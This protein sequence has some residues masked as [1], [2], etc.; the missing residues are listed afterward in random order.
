MDCT[1]PV[2]VA[3]AAPVII[4]AI[5]FALFAVV[6][7]FVMTYGGLWL[8]AYMSNANVGL[9]EMVGMCFRRVSARVI[10]Q[11]KIMAVQS[12]IG[13]EQET[14]VTTQRLEYHYLAG[15]NVLNVIRAVIAAHRAD[16]DLDFDR[17]AEID[18]AGRDVLDE[19]QTMAGISEKSS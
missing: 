3:Q 5:V 18:L 10:V 17:A 14:G 12:G 2:L 4:G 11:A 19:V 8:Q 16:I 15:G 7:V 1:L 6:A 13:S 9:R